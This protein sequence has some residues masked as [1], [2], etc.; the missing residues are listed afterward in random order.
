M[1]EYKRRTPIPT[2]RH[3]RLETIRIGDWWFSN[4]VATFIRE[5]LKDF[6]G[7]KAAV[8]SGVKSN[9]ASYQAST[10]LSDPNVN[11]AIHYILKERQAKLEVS[12][13]D[14][15]RHWYE[16]ATADASE[17][18]PIKQGPCRYCYGIDHRYQY[19]QA[20]FLKARTEHQECQLKIVKQARTDFD[21]E[22]GTGFDKTLDPNPDCPECRGVGVWYERRVDWNKISLGARM[23][24]NGYKMNKDGSVQMMLRDRTRAMENFASLVGFMKQRR[25]VLDFDLDSLDDAKVNALLE[26]AINKGLLTSS[27]IDEAKMIDITPEK[28]TQGK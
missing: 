5:Y 28:E 24:F 25:I 23:L 6:N 26:A 20:E 19:T 7:L 22:G 14:V 9:I 11:L 1:T 3:S 21:E 27:D 2:R 16:L 12:S 10:W 17:L 15:A 8:R 4:S 13:D 18:S